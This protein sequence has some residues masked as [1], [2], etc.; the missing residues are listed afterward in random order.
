MTKL[1]K[2]VSIAALALSAAL[3]SAVYAQAAAPAAPAAQP[4]SAIIVVDMRRVETES[5]AGRSGQTQ[6][7]AKLDAVQ[8][9]AKTL[10]DGLRAEEQTLVRARETNTMAQ[11]AFDAK[12]REL[13]GK[14]TTAQTEIRNR[15]VDLQR[16]QQFVSEQI[17]NALNPIIQAVMRERGA[18]LALPRDATIGYAPALDVTPVVIQRLDAAL[19]RVSVTPPAAAA[20][21]TTAPAAPPRQ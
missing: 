6:L 19:P 4:Q 3:P 14:Q 1:L 15:E 9:R 18:A 5:A 8:A 7:K 16:S 12:V 10:G 11:A 2:T 20:P 17:A 21:T 13:Q